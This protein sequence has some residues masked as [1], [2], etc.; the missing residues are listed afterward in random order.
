[1][2]PLL[3]TG[4]DATR[5]VYPLDGKVYFLVSHDQ[6]K[7]LLVL[8]RIDRPQGDTK[9]LPRLEEAQQVYVVIQDEPER[10]L[11]R[12]RLTEEIDQEGRFVR[13]KWYPESFVPKG[14]VQFA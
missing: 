3:R 7:K 5:F 4:D 14:G 12:G 13:A 2:I 10:M 6:E 1:M 11:V 8:E 9:L